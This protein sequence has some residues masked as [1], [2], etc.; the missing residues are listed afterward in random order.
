MLS[1]NYVV[2]RVMFALVTIFVSVTL[3]FFLFRV[4]KGSPIANFARVPN[5]SPALQHELTVQ[6]GLDKPMFEQY[7]LYLRN[8]AHGNLG[9][10]F[11][12]RQPV[13]GLLLGDLRNTLYLVTAGTVLSIVLGTAAGVLSA[14][15]RGSLAD[16]ASSGAAMLAY[17]LPAQWLG[18]VLLILFVGVLPSAGMA[19]PFIIGSETFWQHLSDVGQH[20]ILPTATLTLTGYGSYMLVVRSSMLATLGEDYVLTA[21]AKGLPPWRIVLRHAARNA[22]LPMVT[23]VA[24]DIGYIVGGSILIEVLFS[25]PGIGDAVF[26]AIGQRDYPMLQ[27]GFLMLTVAVILMNLLADLVY[28]KLD[29]RVTT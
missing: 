2:K 6:F 28:Y 14:W 26:T 12:Y 15:R 23:Q 1:A 13:S 22:M 20:M 18:L 10:S 17:A 7:M 5:A 8:L 11:A 4:M 24:L 25:W 29:P 19:D 16:H 27:G 21:R 9:V 3:N